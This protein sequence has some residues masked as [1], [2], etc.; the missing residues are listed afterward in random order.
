M[1]LTPVDKGLE[2]IVF[3]LGILFFL[4][5][6][7]GELSGEGSILAV[8]EGSRESRLKVGHGAVIRPNK[9]QLGRRK[10]IWWL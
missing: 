8:N 9:G 3:L 1:V 5:N 7:G 4:L 2:G 6:C 10:M